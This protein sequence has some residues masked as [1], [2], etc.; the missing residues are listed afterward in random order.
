MLTTFDTSK[1]TYLQTDGSKEGLGWT[2]YQENKK[3]KKSVV[4]VGSMALKPA[5]KLYSPVKIESLAIRFT[6]GKNEHYLR[7]CPRFVIRTDCK[8]IKDSRNKEL[9]DINNSRV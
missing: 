2:L 7:G 1:D 8:R 3:R 4:A 6:V 5:Q 9:M